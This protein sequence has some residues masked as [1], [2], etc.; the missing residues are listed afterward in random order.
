MRLSTPLLLACSS[1]LF[2]CQGP[3]AMDAAAPPEVPE[4]AAEMATAVA[5]RAPVAEVAHAANPFPAYG[6]T[7]ANPILVGAESADGG[8]ARERAYLS[9]LRGPEFQPVSFT[10][11]GSCCPFETPLSTWGGLL[12]MYEVTYE[13]LDEPVR[14]YL[15][16]YDPGE[17]RPPEGFVQ[18]EE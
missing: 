12:D 5:V 14:L 13:G 8:P 15:N 10:R 2:A 1:L 17:A 7:E 11:L 9:T 4:P 3:R 18:V 6:T 16:M